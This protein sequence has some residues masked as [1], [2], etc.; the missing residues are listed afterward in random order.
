MSY[1]KQ[2]C[3]CRNDRIG[4]LIMTTPV[5]KT[6][7]K[8]WP[9]SKITLLC[10]KINSKVLKNSD[11][12]DDI[13]I[14]DN[15]QSIINK[16][17][18]LKLIRRKSFDLYINF[19]PTN[20]NYIFCFF[21][22]ASKKATIIFLSRYK[23][24]FSKIFQRF[25]SKIYCQHVFVVNRRYRFSNKMNMHQ[26][27]MMLKLIKKIF[28]K[29]LLSH[30]MEIPVVSKLEN[31]IK[32]IFPKKIITIHLSKRWINEYYNI[33]D[34]KKLIFS[35]KNKK[36][37]IYFLT[38]EKLKDNKFKDITRNFIY[39]NNKDF[40]NRKLINKKIKK[41]NI[42][43]LDN[44]KY[45]NWISVIKQ[46]FQVITPECGCIHVAAAFKVPVFVIYNISNYPEYMYKEYKPWKSR[47]LK[48]I[49]KQNNNINKYIIKKLN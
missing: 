15:E 8:N 45:N 46:S 4:D 33:N 3:V 20:L 6:I 27:T 12:I 39:L 19:A 34:L 1:L 30:E 11:L 31:K 25:F 40:F 44:Y 17:K 14:L 5:L 42:F 43:I 21:S 37:Y 29:S 24:S 18:T 28:N 47:H 9:K 38:T 26:T 32:K 16:F 23:K 7:R 13:I 10:S 48:L 49:F 41:S 2:I 36:K 22:R 35:L